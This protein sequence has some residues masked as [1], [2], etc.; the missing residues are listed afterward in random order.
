MRLLCVLGVSLLLGFA[1]SARA[2]Q[3]EARALEERLI[4]PCCWQ[5]S[6]ASHDAPLA[7]E[8]RAEIERR[9]DQ[10]QSTAVIEADLVERYGERIRAVPIGSERL[11]LAVLGCIAL[12]LVA[13][14]LGARRWM[15]RAPSPP[16]ERGA[17]EMTLRDDY[18]DRIDQ[19]LESLHDA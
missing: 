4:A 15:Y 12:A 8:L 16:P 9:L 17:E 7:T 3:G 14:L 2:Q 18:D 5:E 13:L 10:G 6:L 19:E 11:G 1:C